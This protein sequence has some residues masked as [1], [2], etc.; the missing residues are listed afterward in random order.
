MANL[1][2]AESQSSPTDQSFALTRPDEQSHDSNDHSIENPPSK[3][4]EITPIQE[5]SSPKQCRKYVKIKRRPVHV[6]TNLPAVDQD[7]VLLSPIIPTP[8]RIRKIQPSLQL[9]VPGAMKQ[10]R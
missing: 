5:P 6:P 7:A 8:L 1:S 3:S 9:K 2:A 4:T 10:V